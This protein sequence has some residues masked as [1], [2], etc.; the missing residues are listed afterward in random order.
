MIIRKSRREQK[1]IHNWFIFYPVW[2]SN[3]GTGLSDF[4]GRISN[5]RSYFCPE[6]FTVGYLVRYPVSDQT[7]NSVDFSLIS[8][9][10]HL[11]AFQLSNAFVRFEIGNSNQKKKLL[12]SLT[13]DCLILV[14][15]FINPYPII[16]D[17]DPDPVGSAVIWFR[18]S[19]YGGI[20]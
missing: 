18:G 12:Y 4:E 1:G 20:L 14:S 11:L 6:T 3:S 7:S 9:L 2:I 5:I 8:G 17:E 13:S 16:S 19:G 10:A 15:A